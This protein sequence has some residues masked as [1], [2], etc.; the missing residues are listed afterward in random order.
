[1]QPVSDPIDVFIDVTDTA[2]APVGGLKATDFTVLVDGT[3]V[4]S[5]TFSLPPSQDPN[6]HVSVVFAMDMSSSVQNTAL[7]DMQNAVIAFIN[8]MQ[9]GDYAAIVKFNNS[10]PSKASVVQA[11]TAIDHAAGTS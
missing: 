5:P 6:R 4:A 1:A 7:V 11:F 3:T 8:A 10:N 9:N 2:G